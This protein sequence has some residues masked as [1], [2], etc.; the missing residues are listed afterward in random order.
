MP[1]MLRFAD[2]N[3]IEYPTPNS[4][5]GFLHKVAGQMPSTELWHL[6]GSSPDNNSGVTVLR[7]TEGMLDDLR[8]FLM[9]L[10]VDIGLDDD[11][12]PN[13][14]GYY[15]EHLIDRFSWAT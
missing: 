11:S 14:T 4:D 8:S 5:V 7:M 2:G 6:F 15:I 10:R 12:E 3:E 13:S 1:M 9:D